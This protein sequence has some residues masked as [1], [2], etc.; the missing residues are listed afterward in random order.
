MG[1]RQFVSRYSL[2]IFFVLAYA[3]SWS[4]V[5]P[6]NGAILPWGPAV[7]AVIVLGIASGRRGLS[8]LWQ[9][10]TRW[11]VGWVWYLVAPGLVLLYTLVAFVVARLLG[12][13]AANSAGLTVSAAL[14][15]I[16]QLLI[17]GGQWEEPGWSG[18]ALPR[19]QTRFAGRPSGILLASLILGVLRAGWHLPLVLYGHIPWYDL[20]FL[21]MAFQFL[22]TWQ[23]NRTRGSVLI[24]MLFHYTSNLMG[25][26]LN[27]RFTGSDL[28]L[29]YGLFIAFAWLVVFAILLKEGKG[30]GLRSNLS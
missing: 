15:T 6:M 8:E 23:Y 30:L 2:V 17:L 1:I 5:I 4:S 28:T 12:A 19:L 10:M 25:A 9:Q 7:A 18:F 27:S 26:F 3:I 11:R 14:M 13:T 29:F 20:V 22:I 16:L 24:V 21:P